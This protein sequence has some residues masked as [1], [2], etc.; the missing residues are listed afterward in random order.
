MHKVMYVRA[1][2]ANATNG[3]L[4]LCKRN[5]GRIVKQPELKV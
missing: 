3:H 4:N 1:A 5:E 2:N